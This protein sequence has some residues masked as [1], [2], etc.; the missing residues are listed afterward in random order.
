MGKRSIL[1]NVLKMFLYSTYIIIY[2]TGGSQL[3]FH[4]D[5]EHYS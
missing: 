4:L 5:Q 1:E 3:R 2:N